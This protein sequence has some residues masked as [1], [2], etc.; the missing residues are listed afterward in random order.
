MAT[1]PTNLPVPSESP[2][3]LKFNA[4]KIDEFV[5]SLVNT[6]TDRFGNEH[7]TIEGLRWLAQ[8]A[9]AQYGWIPFGTFQDGAILTL[10]NQI[11]KDEVSGEYYRWDGSLPKNVPAGS[12]P[13][14][15]GGFGVGAWLSVGDSTLKAML[16]SSLGAGMVGYDSGETY[17]PGTVG[18]ALGPYTATGGDNKYSKED[19]ARWEMSA[20]EFST[21]LTDISDSV[22]KALDSVESEANP[23]ASVNTRG[24]TVHLTRGIYPAVSTI[25]IN[26]GSSGVSGKS[27]KGDGQSTTELNFAGAPAFS[28]GIAGN[29]TG[30][31]Y[32]EVSDLK[33]KSA[34]RSGVRFMNYSRMTFRNVQVENC[35]AHG[36][37][38]G[39]GFVVHF[40]KATAVGTVTG[41]G[42]H[43]DGAY[44]HT[45]HTFTSCYAFGSVAGS[46]YSL[47][48]MHYSALNACA[49]DNNFLFGYV[50]SKTSYGV[51]FNGCGSESNGRSGF[52]VISE[53][54][55]DNIRGVSL[56]NCYAYNNNTGNAGYPNLL[57]VQS[58][59][60]G[61][62]RASLEGSAS[63]PNGP[64]ASS[65]DVRVT[66][67][68][69]R[70]RLHRDNYLPNGWIAESGGYIE[71][72]H[73]GVHL[74]NRTV[75]LATATAVCNLKSTQGYNN[76]Y[77]GVITVLASNGHPSTP[78]RNTSIYHLLVYKTIGGGA[79][80]DVIKQAGHV[81]TSGNY[82]SF[83]SFTWSVNPSTNQLIAT[84]NSGAGGTE[85]WF[86]ITSDSQIVAFA[87]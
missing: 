67:S 84:P 20:L 7:Y 47:G 72:I 56:R 32:G 63:I 54:A 8:Q 68:G 83:P 34:P 27:V 51:S 73:E 30:P 26:R 1:Q 3:D 33:V 13:D 25:N 36:F 9:I 41:N 69:A 65:V 10:P 75:P 42:F 23:S 50:L 48:N 61:E 2:R 16:A 18:E 53:T 58:V 40:D 28:D 85:F 43:L 6:Y 15:T 52:A 24:G 59:A 74:I 46:G 80:A 14:T 49:S 62:A 22:N 39:I 29:G 78:E 87:F 55:S 35:G 60:G 45:S 37:W 66:G 17:A 82:G 4:G 19:R 11:L 86:E 57:Y 64:G 44:Q 31:A 5:T 76:R 77:A 81:A 38:G 71:Y 70:L 12:T 21:P 79:G